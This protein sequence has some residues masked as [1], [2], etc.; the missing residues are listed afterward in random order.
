MNLDI[1][2]TKSSHF[3][4][5][6]NQKVFQDIENPLRM[7]IKM[8]KSIESQLP[9]YRISQLSS[10]YW[11]ICYI[12]KINRATFQNS[13]RK[14]FQSSIKYFCDSFAPLL[15]QASLCCYL[16]FVVCYFIE[17][18]IILPV[19]EKW[20]NRCVGVEISYD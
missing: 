1:D 13:S 7:F 3:L 15:W 9:H 6:L 17:T 8:Q 5:E 16:M 14:I 12:Y 4:T 18:F 10:H 20:E 2:D 11:I 19:L